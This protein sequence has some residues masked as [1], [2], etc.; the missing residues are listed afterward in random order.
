MITRSTPPSVGSTRTDSRSNVSLDTPDSNSFE[1]TSAAIGLKPGS[2]RTTIDPSSKTRS[3]DIDKEAKKSLRSVDGI[4]E[5][6][7]ALALTDTLSLAGPAIASV[8]SIVAQRA[9]QAGAEGAKEEALE[10]K[11]LVEEMKEQRHEAKTAMVSI[12]DALEGDNPDVEQLIEQAQALASDTLSSHASTSSSGVHKPLPPMQRLMN[13][14]QQ[15]LQSGA[16]ADVDQDA[17]AQE[18]AALSAEHKEA[19]KGKRTAKIEAFFM[20]N[21]GAPAMNLMSKGMYALAGTAGAKFF[22]DLSEQEVSEL[23]DIGTSGN[24]LGDITGVSKT[25]ATGIFGLANTLMAAFAVSKVITGISKRVALGKDKQAI[26][27]MNGISHDAKAYMQDRRQFEIETN[28]WDGAAYGVPTAIGQ[29]LFAYS[30]VLEFVK[31]IPGP[32]GKNVLT[33]ILQSPAIAASVLTLVPAVIRA[34]QETR[35]GKHEGNPDKVPEGTVTEPKDL[36]SIYRT[37][38]DDQL[39]RQSNTQDAD[40]A[41]NTTANGAELAQEMK[42]SWE[43][44]FLM[45]NED[46][47]KAKA[48]SLMHYATTQHP[49]DPEKRLALADKL[50]GHGRTSTFNVGIKKHTATLGLKADTIPL[51]IKASQRT[52]IRGKVQMNMQQ[53]YGNVNPEGLR[54]ILENPRTSHTDIYKAIAVAP[55]LTVTHCFSA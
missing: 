25:A 44:G 27:R 51:S 20:D 1:P 35:E 17:L 29:S 22:S 16:L 55:K 32:P 12:I 4:D 28:R 47:A 26:A 21:F 43:L 36:F 11:A 8:L 45:A 46:L 40:N 10:L 18:M 30:A 24:V 3:Q 53:Q 2:N 7:L 54:H 41:S 33:S 34:R 19:S 37:Q 31:N 48:L 15:A 42:Y 52:T 23:G 9:V 39:K 50:I 13:R 49:D 5:L 38:A 6:F 14:A